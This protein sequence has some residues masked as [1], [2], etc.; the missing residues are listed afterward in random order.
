[1]R[2]NILGV[3]IDKVSMKDAITLIEQWVKSGGKHYI[4]TPNIE[5]I[6]L[7]QK[8]DEFRKILNKADLA[9][10]DSARLG[11]SIQVQ[12]Q[13]NVFKKILLWPFFLFPKVVGGD[14]PVT[15]GTDLMGAL[16]KLSAEKGYT[17][18]FLGG[19][20]DTAERLL[21]TVKQQYP[22]LRV[23]LVE[24]EVVVNK[25]GHIIEGGKRLQG[26]E[27]PIDILFVAFGQ[28]KQEKWMVHNLYQLPVKL[29]I[30]VGGAFDYLSGS[31]PRAPKFMQRTGFE[32]VYR[33]TLQPWR[34]KRFGALIKF[35][36]CVL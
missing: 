35:V 32:W 15:T 20:G 16:I 4:V 33:L 26:L 23:G 25:E 3:G 17:V 29:M 24:S 9:I 6:M 12:S 36:F 28:G 2:K 22:K 31:V 34:I 8:D 18:G 30:G 14:F 21:R 27:L 19:S 1:M 11:W 13:K 5:F 7:A 10:P